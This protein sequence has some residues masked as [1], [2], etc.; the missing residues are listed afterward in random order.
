MPQPPAEPWAP[1]IEVTAQLAGALIAEQFPALGPRELESEGEG[2]DNAAYLVNGTFVFRFP[3]RSATTK[4]IDRESRLLP[5]LAPRLPLPVPAP[6]FIGRPSAAYPWPFAGY[7]RL[8]GRELSRLRPAENEYGALAAD[9]GSFL[10]A[11]HSL[12]AAPLLAMGLAPDEIGRLDDAR[13]MPK[14]RSRVAVLYEAGLVDDPAVILEAV[15]RLR[16]IRPALRH[17]VA[18]GDLYARHVL[19]NE[20]LRACGIIDWGDLHYGDPAVDLSI[21]FSLIPPAARNAF[22]AAY[23][24]LD[25]RA[26]V[27]A[28]FRAIY[29]SAMVAHYGHR[30][31]DADL[32]YIGLRGLALAAR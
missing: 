4:L 1:D 22:L 21:V 16:P 17:T 31:A 28:R 12:D 8:A 20:R 27:P 2:W 24:P 23:G 25:E 7:R 13:M 3:R 26:L 9:L 14:L 5:S 11:L 10:R 29:H 30:I 18:H 19:V 15:E 32:V 6:E